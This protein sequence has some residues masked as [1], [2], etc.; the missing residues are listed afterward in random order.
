M[1]QKLFIIVSYFLVLSLYL[2][3]PLRAQG[4]ESVH[5]L[6]FEQLEDSLTLKPKKVFIDFYT[7][8]CTYCRKMDK[9]VFTK[10]V[11]IEVLNNQYYAVRFDAETATNVTF[12]GQTFINNQVGKSRS[13]IHQIAQLLAL[14]EGQFAPPTLVILDKTF[15]VT[16]RYFEYMDSEKLLTALE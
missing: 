6:T 4:V 13:P 15:K 16:A 8:W 10:P 7:D 14:K 9:V 2:Y 11:V 12:S 5:W 1:I 3:T